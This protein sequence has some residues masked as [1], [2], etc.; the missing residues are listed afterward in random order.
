MLPDTR[1]TAHATRKLNALTGN[2]RNRTGDAKCAG[3]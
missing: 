1:G 3:L 2:Q